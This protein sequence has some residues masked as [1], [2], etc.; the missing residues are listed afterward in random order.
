MLFLCRLWSKRSVLGRRFTGRYHGLFPRA[1]VASRT[2]ATPH[3]AVHCLRYVVYLQDVQYSSLLLQILICF[4]TRFDFIANFQNRKVSTV[5]VT[6]KH[7]WQI[8][9][10]QVSFFLN[11]TLC[12]C[13]TVC[14]YVSPLRELCDKSHSRNLAI[15][16]W[17]LCYILNIYAKGSL[18]V[19]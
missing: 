3:S 13:K 17:G 18:H 7:I 10:L 6:A 9:L 19:A 1:P 11:G 12:H 2:S 4:I 8:V 15:A 5:S 16:P 14:H